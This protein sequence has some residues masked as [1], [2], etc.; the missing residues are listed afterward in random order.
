MYVNVS[1]GAWGC[2]VQCFGSSHNQ[3]LAIHD[4]GISDHS[5]ISLDRPIS[6]VSQFQKHQHTTYVGVSEYA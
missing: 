4:K 5:F 3:N 2:L 6:S 1:Y